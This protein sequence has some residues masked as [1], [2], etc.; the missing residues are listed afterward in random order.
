VPISFRDRKHGDSKLKK[1]EFWNYLRHSMGLW[2][3]KRN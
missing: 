1:G 3:S 2:R